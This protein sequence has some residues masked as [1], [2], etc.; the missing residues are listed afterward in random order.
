MKPMRFSPTK[1][2]YSSETQS[3]Y[4][5]GLKYSTRTE[6]L[7]LLVDEW[8]RANKVLIVDQADAHISERAKAKKSFFERIKSWL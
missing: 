5:A 2:F 6:R 4:C 1:N 7:A 8:V 3:M